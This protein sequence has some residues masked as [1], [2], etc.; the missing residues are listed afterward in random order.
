[1]LHHDIHGENVARGLCFIFIFIFILDFNRHQCKGIIAHDSS[2]V[3][4]SPAFRNP[5][6]GSMKNTEYVFSLS[7]TSTHDPQ[8]PLILL[9]YR[10]WCQ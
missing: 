9:R 3:K 8:R 7:D 6:K 10:N 2:M 5:I 1:M 4:Q